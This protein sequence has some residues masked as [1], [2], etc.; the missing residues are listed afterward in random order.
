MSN[1]LSGT[2]GPS[3][4]LCLPLFWLL[5]LAGLTQHR[6]LLSPCSQIV[7]KTLAAV[8][9]EKLGIEPKYAEVTEVSRKKTLG[10][11]GL[12]K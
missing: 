10:E 4:L 12:T 5:R 11:S 7:D 3:L 1:R 6:T 8:D 2:W 9:K